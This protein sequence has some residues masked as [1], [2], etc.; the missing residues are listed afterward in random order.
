V[1]PREHD[2]ARI[3]ASLAPLPPPRRAPALTVLCGLP[4]SGKSTVAEA[5]R[6]RVSVAVVQSDR[7]RK[8]L[9]DAPTYSTDESARVFG[10]IHTVVERL[11]AD[12]VPVLLDATTLQ[13]Q[14]RAPLAS[15]ASRTGARLI[16]VWVYAS[17]PEIR[18]R[19]VARRQGKRSTYDVSD[20]DVEIYEM[21]RERV[22]PIRGPHW[23][24]DTGR[25][26]ERVVDALARRI[27]GTR[28][29]SEVR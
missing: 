16:L 9:I 17:D 21:M 25:N 26:I 7:I 20:A 24:I 28:A 3:M 11:L 1:D 22:E 19:L 10:A 12:G 8:L 15:I 13:E 5:V 23:R 29:A 2:V 18:R 4:G 14:Q 6:R 27:E